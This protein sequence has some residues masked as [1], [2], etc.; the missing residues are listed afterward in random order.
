MQIFQKKQ[1]IQFQQGKRLFVIIKLFDF[2]KHF[3]FCKYI[4]VQDH[5]SSCKHKFHKNTCKKSTFCGFN[6]ACKK[7]RKVNKEATVERSG[8]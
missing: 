3:C 8:P 4:L 1:K 5:N 6:F 7:N 2:A